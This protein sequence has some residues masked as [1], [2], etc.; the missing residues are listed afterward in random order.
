MHRPRRSTAPIERGDKVQDRGEA[1]RKI[2][3]EKE[4]PRRGTAATWPLPRINESTR[5][6]TRRLRTTMLQSRLQYS[7]AAIITIIIGLPRAGHVN[8]MPALFSRELRDFYFPERDSSYRVTACSSLH[9]LTRFLYSFSFS[10]FNR[11]E[12]AE[13]VHSTREGSFLFSDFIIRIWWN[14]KN[15]ISMI[16]F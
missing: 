16:Y 8:C 13:N 9:P 12:R 7:R 3:V 14:D 2:G 15:K 6:R 11:S 1:S 5:P 4:V 10:S